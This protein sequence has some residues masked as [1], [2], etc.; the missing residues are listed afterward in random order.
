MA[1]ITAV[2]DGAPGGYVTPKQAEAIMGDNFHGP[3]QAVELL[4]AN[5]S[6]RQKR[7]LLSVPL[8]ADTLRSC[9]STHVLVAAPNISVVDVYTRAPRIFDPE[10]RDTLLNVEQHEAF[11]EVR[12]KAGWYLVRK[13]YVPDSLGKGWTAQMSMIKPPAFVPEANLAIYAYALHCLA[14]GER[15]FPHLSVLTRSITAGGF[16]V[17]LAHGASVYLGAFY[18]AGSGSYL[19]V[20]EAQKSG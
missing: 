3:D 5:F 16:R 2:G 18:S 12:I 13:D 15:M 14:T 4:S 1:R 9:S 7:K 11:L 20:A 8:S 17:A 19:G 10:I 6:S